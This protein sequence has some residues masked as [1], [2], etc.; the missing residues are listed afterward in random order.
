MT[1]PKFEIEEEVIL[2]SVDYPQYNGTYVVEMVIPKGTQ[3]TCR[4]SGYK[5]GINNLNHCYYLSNR[6]T[7][8]ISDVLDIMVE[9][10]WNESSLRK[11]HPPARDDNGEV[12]SYKQM[13][14]N[15]KR[16]TV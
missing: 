15:L 10:G 16:V 4:L 7:M 5:W 6:A 3:C 11:K 14:D 8:I 13:I 2:Q 9:I 1:K 12:V